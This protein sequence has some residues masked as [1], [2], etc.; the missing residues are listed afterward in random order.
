MAREC[1]VCGSDKT[2]AS[3]RSHKNYTERGRLDIDYNR[4]NVCHAAWDTY[5]YVR[6][7]V[8]EIKD[9]RRGNGNRVAWGDLPEPQCKCC[10]SHDVRW[11]Y[12]DG[13]WHQ[14]GVGIL[15]YEC[16]HCGEIWLE[17]ARDED[18]K[19]VAR[20]VWRYGHAG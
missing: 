7:D 16:P 1:P 13:R 2:G 14:P 15:R 17:M 12:E 18:G 4:C 20:R 8:I 5:D 11:L 10:K 9:I 6:E 19:R 3:A